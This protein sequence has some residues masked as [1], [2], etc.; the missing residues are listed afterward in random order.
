MRI[1]D[2]VICDFGNCRASHS[3]SETPATAKFEHR[4]PVG[5]ISVLDGLAQRLFLG[6]LQRRLRLLVEAR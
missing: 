1:R 2:R 4:L 5:E 6:L 3:D